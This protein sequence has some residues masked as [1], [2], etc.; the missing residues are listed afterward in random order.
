MFN[1]QVDQNK[2]DH[3]MAQLPLSA[4]EAN[5]IASDVQRQ[6]DFRRAKEITDELL[7]GGEIHG[8]LTAEYR[9][10]TL[11]FRN[12]KLKI[13]KPAEL[14]DAMTRRN[15]GVGAVR[16][17]PVT[18][19][20]KTA[21][22]HF[23]P[24]VDRRTSE[25]RIAEWNKART[26]DPGVIQFGSLEP[27]D[28]WA[29]DVFE[30]SKFLV[31][32]ENVC[33][34][35]RGKGDKFHYNAIAN[36]LKLFLPLSRQYGWNTAQAAD[37][38]DY[39]LSRLFTLENS[40]LKKP[41]IMRAVSTAIVWFIEENPTNWKSQLRVSIPKLKLNV[42]NPAWEG[43]LYFNREGKP[44]TMVTGAG[45]VLSASRTIRQQLGG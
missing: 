26:M 32:D 33:L 25:Y 41:N 7:A 18:Q 19:G 30:A 29:R 35:S 39:V 9:P 14:F 6:P 2:P 17:D 24:Y 38:V 16:I 21:W 37:A 27:A 22:V 42:N 45:N 28:V 13:L 40:L 1:A 8:V 44:P 15:G 4:L 36:L 10:G 34:E 23:I 20:N 31:K 11:E 43:I 12:G 3:F 5:L